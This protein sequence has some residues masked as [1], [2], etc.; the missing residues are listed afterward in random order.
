MKT[1]IMVVLVALGTAAIVFGRIITFHD[2][3]GEALVNG[4][5]FWL[6]GCAFF[7]VAFL[8]AWNTRKG[9]NNE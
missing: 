2:T 6:A 7:G 1:P 5:G 9:T 4:L 3:E 8:M